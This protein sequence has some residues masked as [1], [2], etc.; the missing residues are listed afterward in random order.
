MEPGVKSSSTAITLQQEGRYEEVAFSLAG[1]F[2]GRSSEATHIDEEV[3]EEDESL[4]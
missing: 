3:K 1:L 2:S 4:L